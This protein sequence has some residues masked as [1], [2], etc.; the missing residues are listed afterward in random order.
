LAWARPWSLRGRMLR[1]RNSMWQCHGEYVM[2]GT[3]LFRGPL[4]GI[5]DAR[6]RLFYYRTYFINKP[7]PFVG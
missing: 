7:C 5:V 2:I 3:S 4:E 1:V 6:S